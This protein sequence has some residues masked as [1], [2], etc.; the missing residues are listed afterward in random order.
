M[1]ETSI[2]LNVLYNFK[3]L[4]NM[5]LRNLLYATM[6]ACA[7]ASCSNDDDPIDNAGG[8]DGPQLG[9]N[10]AALVVNMAGVQTK[11]AV[12]VTKENDINSAT[13]QVVV[14]N[15]TGDNAKVEKVGLVNEAGSK[16]NK[17]TVTPGDKMVVVLANYKTKVQADITY[18]A[19][20]ASVID[21]ANFEGQEGYLT[22]NSAVY[23]VTLL[24]S[25]T[26]Y[27]GYVAPEEVPATENYL[28]DTKGKPV[29]LYH[30][31]AKVVLSNVAVDKSTVE[32]QY[33]NPR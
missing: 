13:T 10:E 33:P 11:A 1:A 18:S 21:F 6:I 20:K 25:K 8:G 9:E 27:L 22:M 23:T 28:S 26:N 3:K 2:I 12:S 5:K 29:Y 16:T 14:F 24:P 32:T 17:V 7:F 4:K 19:L 30:N 15:G 31:V